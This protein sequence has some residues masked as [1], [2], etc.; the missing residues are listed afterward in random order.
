MAEN[1]LDVNDPFVSDYIPVPE[2]CRSVTAVLNVTVNSPSEGST[3]SHQGDCH[4]YVH[5]NAAEFSVSFY[6]K[7]L[8]YSLNLPKRNTNTDNKYLQK[9]PNY[10]PSIL[11]DISS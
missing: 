7:E 10:I 5:E 8:D 1:K 11:D 6:K 9:K 4:G 3:A 2:T